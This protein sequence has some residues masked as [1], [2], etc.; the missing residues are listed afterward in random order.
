MV[1]DISW[2]LQTE[3][4]EVQSVYCTAVDFAVRYLN[5][6]CAALPTH[7]I[8]VTFGTVQIMHGSANAECDSKSV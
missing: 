7:T 8:R 5:S 4:S 3:S 6:I 2:H 1:Y